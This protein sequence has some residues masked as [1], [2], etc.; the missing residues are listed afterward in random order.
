MGLPFFIHLEIKTK[1]HKKGSNS[2]Y[3]SESITYLRSKFIPPTE[4][5]NAAADDK[6]GA[7]LKKKKE[8]HRFLHVSN[9][10]SI[11]YTLTCQSPQPYYKRNSA[12][13]EKN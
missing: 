5:I 7:I 2:L 1:D 12:L 3:L 8:K 13:N 9:L 6:T 4:F 11:L 10:L